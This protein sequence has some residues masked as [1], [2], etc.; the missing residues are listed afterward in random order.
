MNVRA[1]LNTNGYGNSSVNAGAA[2]V[3]RSVNFDEHFFVVVGSDRFLN[4]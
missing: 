4:I 3:L 2:G 1:S